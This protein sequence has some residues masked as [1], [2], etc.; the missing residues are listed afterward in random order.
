MFGSHFYGVQAAMRDF[1]TKQV[2]VMKEATS[3][4][5]NK[6]CAHMLTGQVKAGKEWDLSQEN[7]VFFIKVRVYIMKTM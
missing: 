1:F 4:Q 2:P 3:A 6:I 7:Q 5:I